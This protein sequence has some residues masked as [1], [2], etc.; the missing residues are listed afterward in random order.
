MPKEHSLFLGSEPRTGG[1]TQKRRAGT[2]GRSPRRLLVHLGKGSRLGRNA[3]SAQAARF[4]QPLP[5][6]HSSQGRETNTACPLPARA[7]AG[8]RKPSQGSSAPGVF[9]PA[10]VPQPHCSRRKPSLRSIN[11]M[12]MSNLG[13]H[14]SGALVEAAREPKF[15]IRGKRRETRRT[16]S[17][18]YSSEAVGS[19]P[20]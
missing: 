20:R 5:A 2:P 16:A 12:E 9:V 19:L 18:H 17:S 6:A 14:W 13:A 15:W 3:G 4:P 1:A 8:S 10:D 11:G 7:A